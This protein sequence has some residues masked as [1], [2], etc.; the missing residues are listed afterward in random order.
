VDGVIGEDLGSDAELIP[1]IEDELFALRGERGILS[2]QKLA[3]HPNLVRVCGGGDLLDAYL[4]FERELRRYE[5]AGRNEAAAAISISAP[6]DTV[7]DRLEH[8][9]GALPQDGKLRDQ[10][11]ARRWSDEGIRTIA[12]DLVYMARVQGR[13]GTELLA[14]EIR[15]DETAGLQLVIDQ[16]TSDGLVARAPLIRLWQYVDDE[17]EERQ[18]S[19]DL[20]EIPAAAATKNGY[21]MR[22]HRLMVEVP[23]APKTREDTM[24][25][26]V[27]VEGRDAPMRTVAVEDR[28]SLAAPY[29]LR[30]NVYRTIISVELLAR[31][32]PFD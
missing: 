5:N 32:V 30:L 16:M 31:A 15:G 2:P 6:A 27:S 10:R 7:L 3:A 12:S 22:R 25:L 13:L 26:G 29:G 21:T 14:I 19:V 28:S 24:L 8:A 4:M 17:P 1:L 23:E 18:L 9:V 11:T 20:D